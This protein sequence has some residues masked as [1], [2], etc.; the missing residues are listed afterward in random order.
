MREGAERGDILFL[1]TVN[2]EC[3]PAILAKILCDIICDPLCADKDE[4]LCVLLTDL[5]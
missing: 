2:G 5:I 3:G 4:D 1:V